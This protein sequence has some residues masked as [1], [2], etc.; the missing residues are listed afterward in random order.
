MAI[1]LRNNRPHRVN[2]DL[3]NHVLDIMLSFDKSSKAGQKIEL[4]TT[5]QRPKA[6]PLGLE[7]GELDD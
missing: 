2:G 6:L 1:A 4:G 5:C 3:A 7:V